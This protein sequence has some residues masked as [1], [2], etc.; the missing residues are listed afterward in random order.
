MAR[1]RYATTT[2]TQPTGCSES[3]VDELSIPVRPMTPP[4]TAMTS[5]EPIAESTGNQANDLSD[6][7]TAHDRLAMASE[8]WKR[9]MGQ[10]YP[11]S[12]TIGAHIR[13]EDWPPTRMGTQRG[14][15]GESRPEQ[16]RYEGP[17][18]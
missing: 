8:V 11:R 3:P 15:R 13:A 1:A 7:S 17:G 9:V 4:N 5:S 18:R 16:H 10:Q 2:R 12:R 14:G 6:L